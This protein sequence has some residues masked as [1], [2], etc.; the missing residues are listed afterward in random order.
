MLKMSQNAVSPVKGR[1]LNADENTHPQVENS[2]LRE[3][4][5]KEIKGCAARRNMQVLE[6]T[7]SAMNLERAG[8]KM[9]E[10][11]MTEVKRKNEELIN[12]IG[13]NH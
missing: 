6:K 2:E 7:I 1:L 3:N 8:N 10:R 12:M 11:Q 13:G 5:S 4:V 9:M